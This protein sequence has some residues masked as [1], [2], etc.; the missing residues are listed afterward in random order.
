MK[1]KTF[2][3][4]KNCRCLF[5]LIIVLIGF[6]LIIGSCGGDDD[7]SGSVNCMACENDSE[8]GEGYWCS[9]FVNGPN[10]CVPDSIGPEDAYTCTVTY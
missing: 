4:L 5:L 7:D 2:L 9:S 1:M 10:R 3:N 6:S 8:C